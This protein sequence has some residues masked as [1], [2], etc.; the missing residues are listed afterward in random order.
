MTTDTRP[1]FV[2]PRSSLE[3][4]VPALSVVA[5]VAELRGAVARGW[6]APENA[7]KEMDVELAEAIAREVGALLA[8]TPASRMYAWLA[9]HY[10]I[11]EGPGR[12]DRPQYEELREILAA[13]RG[14]E[15]RAEA[16]RT[17]GGS[18]DHSPTPD[19]T[20]AAGNKSSAN[21]KEAP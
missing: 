17:A 10:A 19:A 18:G 15:G 8:R 5:S 3:Q 21:L 6:C 13:V 1:D 2:H 4:N 12:T 14:P 7:R 20:T 11:E 16:E 9:A